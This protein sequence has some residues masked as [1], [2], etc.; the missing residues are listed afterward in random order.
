VIEVLEEALLCLWR[1]IWPPVR[2]R[3]EDVFERAGDVLRPEPPLYL[4][5][6]D[7]DVVTGI[8][9][10]DR[11]Q[12]MAFLG[13]RHPRASRASPS[14]HHQPH[15]RYPNEFDDEPLWDRQ[16]RPFGR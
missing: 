3:I 16:G 6:L 8:V 14:H 7:G 9:V 4:V 13:T 10:L 15:H 2:R 5:T 11:G 1:R 12:A